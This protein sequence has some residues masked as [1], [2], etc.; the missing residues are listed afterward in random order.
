MPNAICPR[1]GAAKRSPIVVCEACGLD[2]RI[3]DRTLA[4]C[5]LLS[6]ERFD[7]GTD[8]KRYARELEGVAARIQAGEQIP[9]DESEIEREI[10]TVAG[11]TALPWWIGLKALGMVVLWLAPAWLAIALALWLWFRR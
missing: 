1:C 6:V 3:D 4:Q 7:D 11:G 9:F 5:L 10:E 8:R 2:P